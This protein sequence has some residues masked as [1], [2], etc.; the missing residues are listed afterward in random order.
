MN[1]KPLKWTK[2]ELVVG[3]AGIGHAY[4][5]CSWQLRKFSN[6]SASGYTWVVYK[7]GQMYWT[8][9]H[10]VCGR[11]RDMKARVE[12]YAA[13]EAKTKDLIVPTVHRNGT[14]VGALYAQYAAGLKAVIAAKE[15]LPQPHG[16]DYYTQGDDALSK[17]TMQ[18]QAQREKLSDV[19][20][21]L[22]TVLVDIGNQQPEP[23]RE[24][25]PS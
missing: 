20:A 16:R 5:S 14:G 19:E 21:E 10:K 23:A 13:N 22:R 17:A 9:G 3:D 18:F 7:D 25:N 24:R 1:T 4:E 11:L 8:E 6:T 12:K 2:V 15:A